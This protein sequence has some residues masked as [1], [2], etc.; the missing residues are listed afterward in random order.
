MD[1]IFKAVSFV[2]LWLDS[3]QRFTAILALRCLGCITL[4][5]F[6]IG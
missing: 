5:P 2:V 1:E 6:R 4:T 3:R